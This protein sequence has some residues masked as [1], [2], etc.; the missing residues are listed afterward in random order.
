MLVNEASFAPLTYQVIPLGP[1]KWI[2]LFVDVKDQDTINV[3]MMDDSNLL[4][5]RNGER[6]DH[7]GPGEVTHFAGPI[8]LPWRRAWYLVIENR[9]NDIKRVS[10][11]YNVLS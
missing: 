2:D 6:F 7:H 4:L 10:I 11:G 5:F 3:Y 9:S 8:Q 1:K